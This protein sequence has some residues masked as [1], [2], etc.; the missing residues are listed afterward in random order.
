MTP[1][2]EPNYIRKMRDAI[3]LDERNMKLDTKKN[4]QVMAKTAIPA[5]VRKARNIR[6]PEL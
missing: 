4:T 2:R 5:T 3:I 1:L 6:T